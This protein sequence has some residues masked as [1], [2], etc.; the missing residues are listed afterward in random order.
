MSMEQEQRQAPYDDPNYG[1]PSL[2]DAYALQWFQAPGWFDFC[3]PTQMSA[4]S[5]R[6]G[7]GAA[8]IGYIRGS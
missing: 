7:I 5:P 1:V 2:D 3:Y 6:P 8:C 4:L